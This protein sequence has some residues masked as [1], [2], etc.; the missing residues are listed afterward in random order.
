MVLD[1]AKLQATGVKVL[2]GTAHLS[3]PFVFTFLL[4]HLSAPASATLGGSTL[5]SRTMVCSHF[6][7]FWA[8]RLLVILA[9]GK[10]VLPDE[11]YRTFP[12]PRTFDPPC[13]KWIAQ[14]LDLSPWKTTKA[15]F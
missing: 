4:V 15:F 1:W 10:G 11:F 13:T 14:A 7:A 2:G 9:V 5:A 12:C 8:C 6:C 3:A